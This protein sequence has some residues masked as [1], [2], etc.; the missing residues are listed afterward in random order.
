MRTF[1]AAD[2]ETGVKEKINILMDR[3][4]HREKNIKWVKP[5]NIHITIYFF[6]EVN[7][8]DLNILE[9]IIENAIRALHPFTVSVR[10]ISAFPSIKRPRVLWIGVDNPFREL[11]AIY[12]SINKELQVSTI[13]VNRDSKGYTSHITIGRV[14]SRYDTKILKD[15][16]N[17]REQVFGTFQIKNVVLYQSILMKEGPKYEPLKIFEI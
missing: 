12:D 5:E 9:Q 13:N 1:L 14:K 17:N 3:F 15:I 2:I 7:A 6:G 11:N 16:N 4:R 10:E 8:Q